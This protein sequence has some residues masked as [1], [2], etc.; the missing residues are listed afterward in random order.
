VKRAYRI[1]REV[2]ILFD[3][4]YV[5]GGNQMPPDFAIPEPEVP[6][7]Q[8]LG[9]IAYDPEVQEAVLRGKSLLGLPE[10]SPMVRSVGELM[11]KA[12]YG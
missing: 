10:D 6:Q 3:H 5:V 11:K 4:F 12:G 8:Y 9:S 7:Q 1:A 2:G